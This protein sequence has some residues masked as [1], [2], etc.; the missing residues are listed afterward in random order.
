MRQLLANDD[1]TVCIRQRV[2]GIAAEDRRRR[3]AARARRR[4][5]ARLVLV[6]A[7]D[8]EA[9]RPAERRLDSRRVPRPGSRARQGLRMTLPIDGAL[10]LAPLVVLVAR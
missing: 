10:E 2:D 4:P 5:R 1:R 9:F 8:L 7:F 3:R 6:V